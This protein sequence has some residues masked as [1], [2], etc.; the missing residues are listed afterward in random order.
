M[1]RVI[2]VLDELEEVDIEVIRGIFLTEESKVRLGHVCIQVNEKSLQM[3]H[4]SSLPTDDEQTREADKQL[5]GVHI[6]IIASSIE[7]SDYFFK[8]SV[9]RGE[10]V[11][12]GSFDDFV[13][14]LTNPI[15]LLLTQRVDCLGLLELL[16][17]RDVVELVLLLEAQGQG[18]KVQK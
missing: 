4:L 3:R 1:V 16:S 18:Y 7:Q 8:M 12:I 10:D 13:P 2:E 5:V 14:N 11:S 6:N 9:E 17:L 15:L